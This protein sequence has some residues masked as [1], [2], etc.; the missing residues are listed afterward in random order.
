MRRHRPPPCTAA[1]VGRDRKAVA[2]GRRRPRW[3]GALASAGVA[4]RAVPSSCLALL[5]W[6]CRQMQL[7]RGEGG[8]DRLRN[9][10][11]E[12]PRLRGGGPAGRRL[13]TR[14]A[15]RSRRC[16][17]STSRRPRE[18]G[19][20]DDHGDGE[21][22]TGS[23][24]GE[25]GRVARLPPCAA[26]WARLPDEDRQRLGGEQRQLRPEQEDAVEGPDPLAAAGSWQR[27]GECR[28]YQEA[29]SLRRRPPA[30]GLAA[31]DRRGLGDEGLARRTTSAR[32]TPSRGGRARTAHGAVV[33]TKSRVERP[34]SSVPPTAAACGRSGR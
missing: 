29:A 9:G 7:L 11:R 24:G 25:V 34:S 23:A 8:P 15:L 18:L 3:L 5:G 1:G 19:G 4:L 16:R 20:D 27:P 28:A 30:V 6:G 12:L 17:R 31:G 14:P 26:A 21:H 22:R 13:R 33:V 2:A 10:G 32:L